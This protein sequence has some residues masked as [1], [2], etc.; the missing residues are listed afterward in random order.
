MA[1]VSTTILSGVERCTALR[2]WANYSHKTSKPVKVALKVP[3]LQAREE[4]ISRTANPLLA[5]KAFEAASAVESVVL[6]PGLK[7]VAVLSSRAAISWEF[8]ELTLA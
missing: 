7:L 8:M 3:A 5:D 4:A 6:R 2:G 1:S